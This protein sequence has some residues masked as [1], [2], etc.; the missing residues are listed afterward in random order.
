MSSSFASSHTTNLNPNSHTAFP[1]IPP[2]TNSFLSHKLGPTNYLMWRTQILP[3]LK[4]HSLY[5]FISGDHPAPPETI[6]VTDNPTPQPNP[7]FVIWSTQD[8]VVM[9]LLIASLL[10]E[11]VSLIID[12]TTSHQICSILYW[13][14][15]SS[16]NTCILHLNLQLHQLK[17][18]D[19]S[20]TV[21]LHKAKSIV[22]TLA[23]L[24]S[25][26]PIL[27]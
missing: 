6:I 10:E 15:S 19:D 1:V 4:S 22:D 24:V 3:F 11:I 14:F 16:S 12:A 18:G 23:A 2:V 13:T 5:K 7:L 27:I 20:V 17:Q 21:F 8:Q 9:S 25:L 26:F